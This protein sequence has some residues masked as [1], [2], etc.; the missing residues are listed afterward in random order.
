MQSAVSRILLAITLV[1]VGHMPAAAQTANATLNA[2]IN[3]IARL[4]IS[5]ATIT[6]PDGDPDTTPS[7]Q[8]TQGPITLTAK[9]RT[10]PNGGV[11]LTIQASDQ[12]RSG[13]NTIPASS[14]TW[15]A[16]G[17][18]FTGGTLSNTIAQLVASW[19]GSGVRSGT[20][21]FFFRNLWTY[22]TGTYTLT[23]TYTLT[24][25]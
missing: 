18:G 11:T 10:S 23:M 17:A 8:A 25:A 14:I 1:A 2:S 22:A 4:S 21:A 5:S 15:T 6:F 9:A 20:Q 19:T 24:S 3:G 16:A 12:L 7:I 13:L